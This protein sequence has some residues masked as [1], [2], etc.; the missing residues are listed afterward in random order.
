MVACDGLGGY[1]LVHE[2][3]GGY[4]LEAELRCPVEPGIG[5]MSLSFWEALR[6]FT[7]SAGVGALC[8]PHAF[9]CTLSLT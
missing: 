3:L 2:S 8:G 9:R 1:L 7:P 6:L 5:P 4:E